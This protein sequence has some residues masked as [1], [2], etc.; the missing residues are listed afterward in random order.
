MECSVIGYDEIRK[1]STQ[2]TLQNIIIATNV[3]RKYKDVN[4]QTL[5]RHCTTQLEFSQKKKKKKLFLIER[6][7]QTWVHFSDL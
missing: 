5:T 7:R 2:M 1:F 6:E 3:S 4:I